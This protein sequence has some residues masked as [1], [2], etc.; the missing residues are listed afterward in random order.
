MAVQQNT[1]NNK[2]VQKIVT[3]T[4]RNEGNKAGDHEK[5]DEYLAEGYR[6]IDIITNSVASP[7]YESFVSVTVLLSKETNTGIYKPQ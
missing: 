1:P 2:G 3:Y 7:N 4:M 6:V 5:L